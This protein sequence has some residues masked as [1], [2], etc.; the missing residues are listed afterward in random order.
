MGVVIIWWSQGGLGSPLGRHF[1][2]AFA[3]IN[4]T[5]MLQEVGGAA[6]CR[7]WSLVLVSLCV[8]HEASQ[9]Q[10]KGRGGRGGQP[11]L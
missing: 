11:S 6:V 7:C 4:D 5:Q 1:R 8:W 2:Q 9:G 10:A 3:K